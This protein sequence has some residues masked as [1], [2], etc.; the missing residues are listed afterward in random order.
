MLASD[1][2]QLVCASASEMPRWAHGLAGNAVAMAA[3]GST[4]PEPTMLIRW[5]LGVQCEGITAQGWQDSTS[6]SGP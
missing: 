2:L 4:R 6:R 5:C 3:I 1:R